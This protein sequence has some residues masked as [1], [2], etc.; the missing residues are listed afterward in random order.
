MKDEGAQFQD[1]PGA[2]GLCIPD[3]RCWP[4]VCI[5]GSKTDK[6]MFGCWFQRP[7]M[8]TIT[9]TTSTTISAPA[10]SQSTFEE[11][12]PQAKKQKKKEKTKRAKLIPSPKKFGHKSQ[13]C[14][15]IE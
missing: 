3:K 15:E 10:R 14:L 6:G 1:W 9:S 2:G 4:G 8:S 11:N 7:T 5:A 13:T 12:S